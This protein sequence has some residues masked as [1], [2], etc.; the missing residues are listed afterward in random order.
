MPSSTATT[1]R[2]VS[3][4]NPSATR[5]TCPERSTTSIARLPTGLI[6]TNVG[7][8]VSARDGLTLPAGAVRDVK[9]AKKVGS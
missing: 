3:S 7:V 4:K 8:G 5:T 9:F 2:S 1:R 6:S